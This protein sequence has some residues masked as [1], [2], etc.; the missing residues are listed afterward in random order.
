MN[1][2]LS[3]AKIAGITQDKYGNMWFGGLGLSR[4]NGHT[5]EHYPA[6][7]K[8]ST[9][10]PD[11]NIR[12]IFCSRSGNLYVSTYS[13]FCRYNYLKNNF[14]RMPFG[15]NA[16]DSRILEVG[17]AVLWMNSE[18]GL[19]VVDE[20]KF[21]VTELAKHPDTVIKKIAKLHI[22]AFATD[23][24][25]KVY[26][27]TK[28][29]LYIINYKTWQAELF[30]H[31]PHDAASLINDDV[32]NIVIDKS[33]MVWLSTTYYGSTLVMFNPLTKK[34][35][36]YEQL[37]TLKK[38]W[39][40]N[41]VLDL[42]VDKKGRLW[43]V[44]L[45]SSLALFDTEK[46]EFTFFLHDEGN[47]A[48]IS[49]NTIYTLFEDREN[50]IW[51]SATNS[52]IDYFIPDNK[53]FTTISRT[54]FTSPSLVD[55]WCQSLA[56][57]K[58][59]NLWIGTYRGLS[60]YDRQTNSFKNYLLAQQQSGEAN[61]SI[62]SL[63]A[64]N[65]GSLWIG[66]GNGLIKMNRLSGKIEPVNTTDSIPAPFIS[67][68][69]FDRQGK[70]MMATTRG[71]YLYN[72]DN[73][74][75]EHLLDKPSLTKYK[76]FSVYTVLQDK[77]GKYWLSL[78]NRGLL[79]YN[80][81]NDA[82]EFFDFNSLNPQS[83]S[84]DYIT[85]IAEDSTGIIWL[86]SNTG[87]L[88]F[89]YE[90]KMIN[91]FYVTDGLPSNKTSGLMVD[92]QNRLWIGTSHGLCMLDSKR[93]NFHVFDKKDGLGTGYFYEGTAF[94]L[95][96]GDFAYP[97]YNGVLIFNPLK[98]DIKRG[99][100]SA[101]VASIKISGNKI[102]T[103]VPIRELEKVRLKFNQNFFTIELEGLNYSDP[104][105]TIFAYKLD[106]FNNDWV[107]TNERIVN[108]TNVPG[109]KYVFRYKA[110]NEPGNWDV[111]EKQLEI[112]VDT[113]YYK[114]WW[115]RLLAA[116]VIAMVGY[117]II[118]FRFR[119]QQRMHT[120][121]SRAQSL[122]KEKALVMYENLK[123]Q[124]NPHFLFNSLTSL[125]NLIRVDQKHAGN[126][127]E[128]MSK[129]YRYILKSRESELVLL[130]DEISF[131]QT[132]I[133]LQQT[134]FKNGL[135]VT[136]NIEEE[137]QYRKIVPVTLQ[138]LIDNAIKHNLVDEE[139]PLLVEIFSKDEYLIVQN[140]LQKK[141]FVETSNKQGLQSMKSLYQYLDTRLLKAGEDGKYFIVRI[142]LI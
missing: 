1:D 4:Y 135:Q 93:K 84:S 36:N 138:N 43:I 111:E 58:N 142:P 133:E 124:L 7:I 69:S 118:R 18:K 44:T 90:T 11:L 99:T 131:V 106:G 73:K 89:D 46:K 53:Y 81:A 109:G 15:I 114:T 83:V 98:V 16:R 13:G 54:S 78:P 74:R 86:S 113:V 61:N 140:N 56:E 79:I 63:L 141:E 71:L 82:E 76:N 17:E 59:G 57:E 87:L 39:T 5:I 134:R 97:T 45:R 72:G 25:E 121:E 120:L 24:K 26:L 10:L 67:S 31:N 28:S 65:D 112:F 14:Q 116:L 132:Y 62:R 104:S 105:K 125:R 119:Q 126:F 29:G 41:R 96:N 30:K 94:R 22:Y 117:F 3:D 48:S 108:Y 92:A 47:P 100:I 66:T 32:Q 127:L 20:K 27:G 37:H 9:A 68:L 129:I 75:F 64:D 49:S 50:A 12:R 6:D 88:S 110:T 55:N 23:H 130:K 91:R 51:L 38:E 60:Y 136:F 40:D 33:G 107:Y 102:E 139:T 85:S 42:L 122:E 80:P 95:S 70:I 8:D 103:D 21:T 128:R 123:Q 137:Q 52:G 101:A 19:V 77:R 115:F 2:G 34:F 35:T